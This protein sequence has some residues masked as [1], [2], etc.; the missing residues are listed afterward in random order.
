MPFSVFWNFSWFV[1]GYV[2]KICLNKYR[3]SCIF[4]QYVIKGSYNYNNLSNLTRAII[5]NRLQNHVITT[6]N[7]ISVS[8]IQSI[9]TLIPLVLTEKYIRLLRLPAIL[10]TKH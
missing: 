5:R 2:H 10:E 3:V 1:H 9:N 4:E 8:M 6:I 7:K